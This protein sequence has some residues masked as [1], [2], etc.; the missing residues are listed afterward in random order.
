MTWT[1]TCVSVLLYWFVP[2]FY[3]VLSLM[4]A[5]FLLFFADPMNPLTPAE[6]KQYIAELKAKKAADGYARS[7]QAGVQY[8]K[9]KRKYVSSKLDNA[10]GQ[11]G[12]DVEQTDAGGGDGI[13]V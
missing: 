3:L 10:S 4:S 11:M 1:P 7:D 13:V 12:V 9:N 5:F 2:I 6:R 8:R